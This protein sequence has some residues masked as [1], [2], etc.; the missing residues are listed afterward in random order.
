MGE[1]ISKSVNAKEPGCDTSESVVRLECLKALQESWS[2]M[3]LRQTRKHLS[4]DWWNT[5]ILM[6]CDFLWSCLCRYLQL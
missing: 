1:A 2:L 3:K 6:G 5:D 4:V